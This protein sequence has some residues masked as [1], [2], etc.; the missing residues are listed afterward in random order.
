MTNDQKLSPELAELRRQIDALDVQIVALLN[1][2]AAIAKRVGEEKDKSGAPV[3]RPEREAQV[4]KALSAQNSG[5]LKD[6]HIGAI[7]REVMSACRDLERTSVVAF[8]GP[9]GTFSEQA[10]AARFGSSVKGLPVASIAEIFRSVESRQ[11]DFG[12]VPLENSTEGAI[13]QTLDL[14]LLTPLN[15]CAEVALRIEHQ[16][17][18][19]SGS[20]AGVT[21]VAAH[22]QALAQCA[23]W[24]A[25]HA[26]TLTQT[27]VS[28]NAEAARQAAGDATLAAIAGAPAAL[29]YGLRPVATQIQDD[30]QNTTRFGVIG[31]IQTE[32]SGH[33]RTSLALSVTNRAGAVYDMLAPLKAHGV[34]MTRFESRPARTGNWTY[35]FFIDIAGHANEPNVLE[36]LADLKAI[37]GF[38]KVLGAYPVAEG[39]RHD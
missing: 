3:F 5:P 19:T 20:L 24:L 12:V 36:A 22:P 13:S 2:R 26:P 30:P 29:A 32:P 18:T 8:L 35:Y 39:P 10:V 11:A 37:A 16:L 27:P 34:S 25:A 4:M 23:G 9:E 28:S 7:Y 31:W 33:D 1:Q 38:Y 15:L 21:R 17:L 14:L 6:A